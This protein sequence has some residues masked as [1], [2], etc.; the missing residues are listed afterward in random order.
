MFLFFVLLDV[1]NRKQR[2]RR[3]D[4]RRTYAVASPNDDKKN[5]I[6]KA[7]PARD[8]SP[9]VHRAVK[10]VHAERGRGVDDDISRVQH[11]GAG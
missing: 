4:T 10:G 3:G 5:K 11:A 7:Q 6:E 9:T 2:R 1:F 8:A